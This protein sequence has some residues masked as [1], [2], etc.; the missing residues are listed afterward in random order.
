L[1]GIKIVFFIIRIRFLLPPGGNEKQ[2]SVICDYP[3]DIDNRKTCLP[4]P[5][6]AARRGSILKHYTG[7]VTP[8]KGRS[9]MALTICYWGADTVHCIWGDFHRIITVKSYLSV[10]LSYR[11]LLEFVATT[12]SDGWEWQAAV[13]GHLDVHADRPRVEIGN[14]VTHLPA[15]N[16]PGK[17]YNQKPE[18]PGKKRSLVD[19]KNQ[20]QERGEQN[21]PIAR[22]LVMGRGSKGCW[23]GGAKH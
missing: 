6:R 20:I 12:D 3:G 4:M 15:T 21:R 19:F 17:H 13:V 23:G 1:G 2:D 7:I 18:N 14:P 10:K 5:G 8:L 9:N 22:I 11:D 16:T